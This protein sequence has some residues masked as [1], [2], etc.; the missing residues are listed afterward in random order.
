MKYSWNGQKEKNRHKNRIKLGGQARNIHTKWR[1]AHGDKSSCG[2]VT[3]EKEGGEKK[4]LYA[5]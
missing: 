5:V 2:C 4:N 3:K 1:W